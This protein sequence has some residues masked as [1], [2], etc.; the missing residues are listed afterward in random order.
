M[1]IDQL[2]ESQR[3]YFRS[4]AT[5]PVNF[6]IAMLKKL[7]AAVDKYETEIAEAL[8][9]DLGKSDFEGFMCEIGLVRT[10]ISYMIRHT[11]KFA[12]KHR[13]RTPLAQFAS[14]SYKQPSPYGNTLIMSPWNYPFLLT[15][16]P[17]A[18]AIAAGN[19][20]IVKPSAYSPATSAVIEKIITECF[21]PEYVAV[22]TGGRKENAALLEKKFDFVFFTGSQAVGKEVLRHTAEHLTP[23]VLELGGK[24]PC[25]VDSTAKLKLAAKRIVFGK[26]LN[27]GQTCVA[28]DYILCHRDVKDALV[29]EICA[30]VKKQ[31][32]ENPLQNPD[33]GKIV[34]EK[35]FDRL[36]GLIDSK[37]TVLGGN[38]NRETLQIAPTVMD[39]V[40]W[41]DAVMQEEIFGPIMPILTFDS[42][43]EVYA[44]LAEKPKPLAL[45]L[46][47]EDKQRIREV[48]GRCSYGGGCI[49]DTIIHLAT[50]EMS[51]GG[52]GESGMGGY[53]GKDGFDAFSHTKSIVDKKT[54]MDL[55]MRYQPYDRGIYGK[56]L[57]LFLR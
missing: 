13:V 23:A 46:F 16:D 4:G 35:H 29:R 3:A 18:D 14:C 41:E 12:S 51:F 50:S 5:L 24:S 7:Y 30:Q 53:H 28:P 31:Y 43:D 44:L 33:Y 37:K 27:C 56:L 6:R 17:L 11:R 48:T 34:N 36:C 55:P 21:A 2:L 49:N 54:W 9:K 40:T 38:V 25:I 20:A 47:S 15:I 32:G 26:Y 8:T 1:N 39:N 52:V 42:F 10:E 57:H 45:Y 19:T 22:V